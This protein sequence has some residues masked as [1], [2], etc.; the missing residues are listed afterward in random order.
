MIPQNKKLKIQYPAHPILDLIHKNKW[1]QVKDTIISNK[2]IAAK[3]TGCCKSKCNANHS[4]LH[5]VCQFRP[6]LEV[7]KALFRSNIFAIFEKDCKERYAL[8]IACKHGCRPEII[9]FLLEKNPDAASKAD[10]KGRTPLLLAYKSYIFE[11]GFSWYI[12]NKMLME[13]AKVLTKAAPSVLTYQDYR[14]MTALEYGIEEEYQESTVEILRKAISDYNSNLKQER[15]KFVK[16]NRMDSNDLDS[17]DSEYEERLRICTI[18][19][20]EST[21][22]SSESLKKRIENMHEKPKHLDLKVMGPSKQKVPLSR[23]GVN[24]KYT[25]IA[26]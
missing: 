18:C 19:E 9:N 15:L 11:C 3:C 17:T 16:F 5:Y 13:V 8:H 23:S 7:V 6:P 14:E 2:S 22:I 21:T 12:A 4:I 10:T 20:N 25:A 26:A 24:R 1:K